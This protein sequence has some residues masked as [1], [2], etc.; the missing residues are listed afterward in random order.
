[1]GCDASKEKVE[2]EEEEAMGCAT[3]AGADV[4]AVDRERQPGPSESGQAHRGGGGE[5]VPAVDKEDGPTTAADR[6]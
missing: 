6:S 2:V 4:P 5:A 1:M 3:S